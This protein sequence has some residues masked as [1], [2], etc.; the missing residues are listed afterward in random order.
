MAKSDN[1]KKGKTDRKNELRKAVEAVH[2]SS[3]L[4]FL[5]SKLLNVLAH[6]ALPTL[7]SVET[8]RI[9]I[10]ETAK[11]AGFNSNNTMRLKDAARELKVRQIEWDTLGKNSSW[12][13]TSFL[14]EVEFING[15]IEYSIPPKVRKLFSLEGGRAWA[16]IN[17]D[18]IAE[19]SSIY[20][21]KLYENCVR[22][23]GTGSTGQKSVAEWRRLLQ[24]N[25]ALYDEFRYFR[26]EIE[27][28]MVEINETTDITLTADYIKEGRNVVAVCFYVALNQTVVPDNAVDSVLFNRICALGVSERTAKKYLANYDIEY[29]E[30]NLAIVEERFKQGIIKKNVAAY[31]NKALED[32]Y[33]VIKSKV[34]IEREENFARKQKAEVVAAAEEKAQQ[35]R[36]IARMTQAKSM[37]DKTE[38][39]DQDVLIDEFSEHI[40][41]TNSFLAKQLQKTGVVGQLV[42]PVFHQWLADKFQIQQN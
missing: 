25:T 42:L 3:S 20:T 21:L 19:F 17:L 4:T 8:Y 37:F 28:A 5:A 16:Q 22:F 11:L 15:V 18:H 39:G 24:A 36:I 40:R 27:R 2:S 31:L 35:D 7:E 41:S 38:P 33:R 30:G 6:N 12:G 26:R 29:L 34:E 13:I 1:Q 32:D 14:S 9:S 10:K 23:K